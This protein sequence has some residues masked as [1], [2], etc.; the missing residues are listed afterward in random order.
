MHS[1]LQ[2]PFFRSVQPLR[3]KL[4]KFLLPFL[5]YLLQ[6]HLSTNPRYVQNRTCPVARPVGSW[7]RWEGSSEAP[8]PAPGQVYVCTHHPQHQATLQSSPLTTVLRKD[9]LSDESC[10]Q[11]HAGHVNFFFFFFGGEIEAVEC[12]P[13]SLG[14]WWQ[15]TVLT[16]FW[17]WSLIS[18]SNDNKKPVQQR[19]CS[20]LQPSGLIHQ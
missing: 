1:P 12:C 19:Q 13:K 6:S 8:E 7:G 14:R 10:E 2:R 5:E 4:V 3:A 15:G 11:P 18:T 20:A 17:S 9:L 16:L